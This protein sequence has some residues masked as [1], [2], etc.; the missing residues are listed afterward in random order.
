MQLLGGTLLS[1]PRTVAPLH[2]LFRGDRQE[3]ANSLR[4]QGR[5]DGQRAPP[6]RSSRRGRARCALGVPAAA[7]GGAGGVPTGGSSRG[8][9]G[10]AFS[11]SSCGGICL[12]VCNLKI[13]LPPLCSPGRSH[14]LA[15]FFGT[16]PLPSHGVICLLSP[17]FQS[18]IGHP[19]CYHRHPFCPRSL[20]SSLFT[21]PRVVF[22][23]GLRR[24]RCCRV[25]GQGRLP[26]EPS[27]HLCPLL[28]GAGRKFPPRPFPSDRT[29][30]RPRPGRRREGL[31]DSRA[32][33]PDRELAR[34]VSLGKC[35]D[36]EEEEEEVE[37]AEEGVGGGSPLK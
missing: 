20:L 36:A 3:A 26:G 15:F 33:S 28:G 9:S 23:R 27:V 8:E 29:L 32:P 13:P 2:P 21:S 4:S 37:E 14:T 6:G 34:S 35:G 31:P 19:P 1:S 7:R 25:R 30:L 17:R 12:A 16:C 10:T 22:L 24:R 5:A 18:P 11:P